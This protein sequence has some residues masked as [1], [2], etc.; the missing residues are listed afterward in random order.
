MVDAADLKS[1]ARQGVRVRV[2]PSAFLLLALIPA[3]AQAAPKLRLIGIESQYADV[4]RQVGGRYVTVQAI[5]T[6]PNTDPHN[7]ETS[8]RVT[9]AI[10]RAALI[11]ENGAGYDSWANR[12]IAATPARHR[13][14]IDVGTLLHLPNTASDPHLWYD[15][16]T[17]PAVAV[18]VA[19]DLGKIQ[20]AHAAYFAANARR[21]AASLAPWR[22]AIAQLAARDRGAPVAVT[23]PV[24]NFLLNAIGL[25]IATPRPLQA[26]IMNGTDPSPQDIATQETLLRH[27]Q[28]KL[29]VYN[30][31]VTD[32]L[33]RTFLAIA[34]RRGIPVVG[35]Y[36]TMPTPGYSYQSWML[37]VTSSLRKALSRP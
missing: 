24:A 5:E 8:P 13:R 15:P 11:V 14:V 6:N 3:I 31:Q 32:P 12:L 18:A 36:E 23:E 30:E 33:T 21:F 28:V 25:S 9:S 29:L 19:A 17:M 7:F 16:S 10:A 26:A 35:V 2:P 1:V 4:M 20:P 22:T 37:S 34:R 27:H